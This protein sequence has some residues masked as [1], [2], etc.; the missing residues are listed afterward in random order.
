MN[1]LKKNG[2][3]SFRSSKRYNF[4]K[5]YSS[6][7]NNKNRTKGNV[8][9]LYAKYTNLAKEASSAGD[10]VQ[11]EYYH[12]FADHYSRNMTHEDIK[13]FENKNTSLASSSIIL[14]DLSK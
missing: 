11:A 9:N 5:P 13:P 3:S 10:R 1:I 7:S 8:A 12:Q 6:F 2:R 4:S 14:I